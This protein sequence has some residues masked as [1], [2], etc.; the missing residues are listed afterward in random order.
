MISK[1]A[2]KKIRA[3]QIRIFG[4]TRQ[5]VNMIYDICIS[6][7]EIDFI[8]FEEDINHCSDTSQFMMYVVIS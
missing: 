4:L 6:A 1:P 2:L 3:V 5:R 7:N 8:R